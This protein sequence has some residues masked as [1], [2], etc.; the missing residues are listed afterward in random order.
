MWVT[1]LRGA[2]LAL[3]SRLIQTPD[4]GE[5]QQLLLED[6]PTAGSRSATLRAP[7]QHEQTVTR[8]WGS[9]VG[10]PVRLSNDASSTTNPLPCLLRLI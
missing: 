9:A 7:S 8:V 6:G 3:R 10:E 5:S 1:N 4:D 2:N